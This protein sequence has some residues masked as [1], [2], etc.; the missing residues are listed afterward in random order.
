MT[1]KEIIFIGLALAALLAVVASRHKHGVWPT[2]HAGVADNEKML[3]DNDAQCVGDS[4]VEND[5]VCRVTLSN[6]PWRR[7]MGF[8]QPLR[9]VTILDNQPISLGDVQHNNG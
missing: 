1:R 9:S 2:G 5:P 8:Y 6:T 4:S 7:A 3:K